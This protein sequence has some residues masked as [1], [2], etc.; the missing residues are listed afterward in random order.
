MRLPLLATA[1]VLV[2]VA[3]MMGLGFWQLARGEEKDGLLARYQANLAAPPII[4]RDRVNLERDL[5]RRASVTCRGPR[6]TRTVGAGRFGFRLIAD[7]VRLDG[8]ETLVVQLGTTRALDRPAWAGGEVTGYLA[9]APDSRSL[10]G[11]LIDHRPTPPMIVSDPPLMGLGAN[12][13]PSL[14]EVP[15]NHR[16]YAFQW[17]AFA[18]TALV[19]YALALKARRRRG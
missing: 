18:L 4:V 10:L 17:F 2:A 19:I 11:Q 3:L 1:L 16:S 12:P 15:N 6:Q 7:C 13:G 9:Q 5:F 14:S 8:G